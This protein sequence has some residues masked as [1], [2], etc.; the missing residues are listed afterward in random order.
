[1]R[2]SAALIEAYGFSMATYRKLLRGEGHYYAEISIVSTL[3]FSNTG[4][5]IYICHPTHTHFVDYAPDDPYIA[6]DGVATKFAFFTADIDLHS[7]SL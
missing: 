4:L 5:H 3:T 2:T 6:I 1:M 7:N